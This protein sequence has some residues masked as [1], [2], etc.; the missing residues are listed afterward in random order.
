MSRLV[1]IT[2]LF[3]IRD[4]ALSSNSKRS[5]KS[6]VTFTETTFNVSHQ[7]TKREKREWVRTC[8]GCSDAEVVIFSVD[9]L[10]RRGGTFFLR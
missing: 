5:E 2:G 3:A 6:A 8:R 4:I 7:D 9:T 1:A 10:V